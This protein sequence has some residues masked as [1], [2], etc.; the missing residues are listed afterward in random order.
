MI[1]DLKFNILTQAIGAEMVSLRVDLLVLHIDTIAIQLQA[2]IPSYLCVDRVIRA[3]QT[4]AA[5]AWLIATREQ[6]F[7]NGS[8]VST[9]E[10][11][12]SEIRDLMR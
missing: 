9:Q 8:I 1:D 11:H 4:R 7:F 6:L 2:R 5:Y 10:I 12:P 3:I